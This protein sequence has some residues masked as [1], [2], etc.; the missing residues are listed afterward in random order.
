VRSTTT[1]H[2]SLITVPVIAIAVP[3]YS[4]NSHRGLRKI[5]YIN[6]AQ[7]R[8]ASIV[9]GIAEYITQKSQNLISPI[10]AS[11]IPAEYS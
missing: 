4:S 1:F 10:K 6:H 8:T 5:K 9:F 2:F 11:P 3:L 7:L